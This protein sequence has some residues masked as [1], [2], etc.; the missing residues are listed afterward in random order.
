MTMNPRRPDNDDDVGNFSE[1]PPY[2]SN[3]VE[4]QQQEEERTIAI[5]N[6]PEKKP[7]A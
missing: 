2:P 1:R 3:P 7:D 6:S 5:P 4:R